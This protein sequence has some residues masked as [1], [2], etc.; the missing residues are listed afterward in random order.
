MTEL[1][2]GRLLTVEEYFEREV[3]SEE[4][5]EFWDGALRMVSGNADTHCEI[6]M[7]TAMLLREHLKDCEARVFGIGLLVKLEAVNSYFYPDVFVTRDGWDRANKMFKEHP[8]LI[9][10][11]LSE[12]SERLDRSRKFEA[13][14]TL[15]SLEEYVLVDQYRQRVDC[16]RRDEKGLWLL[17]GYGPGEVV[18]FQSVGWQGPIDQLYR[19]IQF[20]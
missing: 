18:N 13:Y 8:C 4:R 3:V 2:Q 14:Q 20:A 1:E 6:V 9:V 7:N 5:H 16:F 15:E 17:Q 12:E 19:N 10:E 11:V